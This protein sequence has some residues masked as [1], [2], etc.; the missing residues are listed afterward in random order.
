MLLTAEDYY[1]E[2]PAGPPWY[3]LIEGTLVQEP[4]PSTDHD[5]AGMRLKVALGL[6]VMANP[7][8]EV[9]DA[10]LDVYLD[11]HN[12]FQPD[13][14]VVRSERAGIIESSGI[15]GAPDLVVEILS[16]SNRR[17]DVGVKRVVY[18]RSGVRELW[19]LDPVAGSISSY[20]LQVDA[21]SPARVWTVAAGDQATS[22]I[23]PGFS[24]PL[25]GIFR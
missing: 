10:P 1:R 12:V 4:S 17:Y 21:E 13:I 24:I 6:F 2:T 23:L 9:F 20:E 22:A 14:F 16:P 5:R 19:L 18:A 8:A 11:R 7:I 3:Q 15:K 25:A